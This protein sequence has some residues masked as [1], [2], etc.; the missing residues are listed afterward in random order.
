MTEI[1]N[2]YEFA[3]TATIEQIGRRIEEAETSA[4]YWKMKYEK[5]WPE[6]KK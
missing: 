1:N 4:A 6:T 2:P 3:K 5:T